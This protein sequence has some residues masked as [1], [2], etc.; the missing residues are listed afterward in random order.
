MSLLQGIDKLTEETGSLEAI[1][2]QVNSNFPKEISA[3]FQKVLDRSESLGVTTTTKDAEIKHTELLN[4][5][6]NDI[7]PQIV[8][9]IEK[10]TNFK[11]REITS[12]DAKDVSSILDIYMLM[13]DSFVESNSILEAIAATEA[14]K[15]AANIELLNDI[16]KMSKSLD[17]VRGKVMSSSIFIVDINIPLGLFIVADYTNKPELQPTADEITAFVLHENG[18]VFTFIEYMINASYTGYYGNNILSNIND[19]FHNNPKQVMKD[20]ANAAERNV[21]KTDNKTHQIMLKKGAMLLK[22]ASD[23]E[24]TSNDANSSKL[25][26][27]VYAVYEFIVNLIGNIIFNIIY[28][29]FMIAVPDRIFGKVF[30]KDKSLSKERLTRRVNTQYERLA[31]EYVSRYQLSKQLNSGSVKLDDIMRTLS[32][33]VGGII[34]YNQANRELMQSRI[35]FKIIRIP[36]MVVNFIGKI[37]VNDVDSVYENDL[38]RFRRNIS[39]MYDLLKNMNISQA[40]RKSIVEDIDEMELFFAQNKHRY[41]LTRIEK[42]TRIIITTPSNFIF[43]TG[44]YVFG[45]ANLDKEYKTLLDEIDNLLSNKSFY[46][47][48]KIKQVLG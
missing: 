29:G 14:N 38:N 12:N 26:A 17:K 34:D 16:T 30:L 31:D 48:E 19:E 28:L 15:Y 2:Y 36:S 47:A 25:M 32:S 11:V 8:K 46:H 4:M 13:D 42:I 27:T 24:I 21:S 3:L 9:V 18:H 7:N 20:V 40:A 5:L 6:R 43:G 22:K 45:N 39:N 1:N 44:G 23:S 10:Y 33:S 41:E 35:I 37:K